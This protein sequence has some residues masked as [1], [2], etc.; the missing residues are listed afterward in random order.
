MFMTGSK[1]EAKIVEGSSF[2]DSFPDL[3]KILYKVQIGQKNVLQRVPRIKFSLIGSFL[4][5]FQKIKFFDF[6]PRSNRI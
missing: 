4:R 6:R 1:M 2:D 3:K 5:K